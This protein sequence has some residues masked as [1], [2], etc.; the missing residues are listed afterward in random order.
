MNI[1]KQKRLIFNTLK[2][3]VHRI[4]FG[5]GQ[6]CTITDR[7]LKTEQSRPPLAM[8]VQNERSTGRLIA[9]CFFIRVRADRS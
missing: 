5:Y 7:V 6:G 8:L 1:P 3:I 9:R 2:I 4:M